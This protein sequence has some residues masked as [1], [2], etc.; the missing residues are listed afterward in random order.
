MKA[1]KFL[2]TVSTLLAISLFTGCGA[3]SSVDISAPETSE[4]TDK[5]KV[6]ATVFPEYD[7][8]KNIVDEKAD[9]FDITLL[10]DSGADL[11]SFQP[12]AEDVLKISE[13][14]MFIYVGG[15]SDEWVDDALENAQ[16]KE[17][18]VIDL[19]EIMGDDAREEEV[20][21]GMQAEEEEGEE[22]EEEEIEYDEHVWLS[23]KNAKL[24]CNTIKDALCEIDP[25]DAEAYKNNTYAYTE[26]F[27]TLDG[28]FSELADNARN[29]TLI[30]GDRF[31]FAYFT[32]DYG[33][34]Y[35]AAFVGCS[36]E[37]EASFETITFL[38]GKVD[39]LNANTVYTIENS[40]NKIAQAVIDVSQNKDCKIAALDSMQSVTGKQ[41][42]EGLTY[43]SVMEKN[44]EVL[45][46]SLK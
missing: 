14:D 5:I 39:E 12:T 41:A 8:V 30:F 45:K 7:W 37:T 9:K 33:F 16:N 40:D 34:D 35:Y 20:K 13:C 42:E 10:Q 15:E 46:E 38:A 29:K 22:G 23:L 21:E 26:K 6:V 44:L 31:P 28:E 1:K 4:N 36:A 24:F 25:E 3:Q 27:E 32:A 17:M 19:M 18:K 11:H 2:K 43:L